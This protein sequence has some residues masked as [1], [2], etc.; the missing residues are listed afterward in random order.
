MH[1]QMSSAKRTAMLTRGRYIKP[2]LVVSFV[3]NIATA[4]VGLNFTLWFCTA[5][6]TLLCYWKRIVHCTRMEMYVHNSWFINSLRPRQNGCYNADDIFKCIFLNENVWF[7]T[8]IS[9]K[10]V[11]KCPINNIQTLVLIMAWRRPGDKPLSEPMMVRLP[12]HICV[13]RPQWVKSPQSGVTLCFQFVS[14]SMFVSTST[15]ATAAM[16]F[17]SHI[18][19]VWAA[20]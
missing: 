3:M 5:C 11:P 20:P 1:L 9:L 19:T 10:F 16:T 14:A 8:K 13:T 12:T 7:P 6:H 18:K 4:L 15:A 17:A 2:R